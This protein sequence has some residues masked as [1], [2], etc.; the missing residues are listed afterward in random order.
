MQAQTSR[1]AGKRTNYGLVVL[2]A[3]LMLPAFIAL[4]WP[5]APAEPLNTMMTV[6]APAERKMNIQQVTSPGGIKAWLVE[7][8]SVPLISLQFAFQGGNSQDPPGKEGV[9]NFLASMLDEGAGDMK[10]E[11]FQERIEELAVQ[12]GFSDSSDFF[13]GRFA[14]LTQNRE[15]AIE[16][17]RLAVTAPRFD[18]D[19]VERVRKQLLTGLSFAERDP[20]RVASKA[21]NALA[22]PGHP[23]GTPANGTTKSVR[24][25]KG[26]DLDALRKKIFARNTL[27]VAAVGDI[28]AKALG[29]LL[30][31]VFGE[32]PE[33]ADLRAVSDVA[34]RTG[35]LEV[36]DMDVP[37]SVAKFGFAA[38]PRKHPDFVPAFVLNHIIGGGGFSSR[39]MEEVREKRGL[40]YSVYSYVEPLRNASLLVGSVATKNEE[41]AQSLDVIKAELDRMAT[42]GPTEKEL[43]DAKSYLTGSYALRFDTSPK[44][45]SQL[46]AIQLEDL[47]IDY[48]ENRNAQIE[49]VTLDDV[50]RVGRN[51]MKTDN[52]VTVV[53]GKPQNLK[54]R[55]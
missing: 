4:V 15:P 28:D 53:V 22:F 49:A 46:L 34:P 6:K 24:A 1:P 13:Q 30:D 54:S 3:V 36:V 50:K 9:T 35:V 41:I 48:I 2:A 18:A 32:L 37:Q 27:K 11:Q 33:K 42:N 43:A 7:D 51:L 40:A 16:M 29:L 38:L 23:Y 14:T 19:A 45:A 8:H 12:L 21:W 20:N 39:L 47:G 52:L 5:K 55:S 17:L 44:I 25:I 10:A 31:R 26:A